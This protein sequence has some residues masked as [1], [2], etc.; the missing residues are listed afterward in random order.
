MIQM[1]NEFGALLPRPPD[2]NGN[3]NVCFVRLRSRFSVFSAVNHRWNTVFG[4]G[5]DR[6]KLVWLGSLDVDTVAYSFLIFKPMLLSVSTLYPVSAPTASL[7]RADFGH[8]VRFY[9]DDVPFFDE[10]TDF[11][12]S[13]LRSREPVIMVATSDHCKLIRR[14]LT[15]KGCDPERNPFLLF[16]AEDT[17]ERFMVNNQPDASR[18]RDLMFRNLARARGGYSRKEQRVTIF[19]EMVAVLWSQGN[20]GAAMELEELWN[21]LARTE[22]FS[23]ICAYPA[24]LFEGSEHWEAFSSLCRKHA[25][26]LPDEGYAALKSEEERLRAI[27]GLQFKARSLEKEM[28]RHREVESSLQ[29]RIEERAAEVEH[30]RTRLQDLSGKLVLMRDQ[31]SQRIARELHDSTSQL[32]SVLAMY[33]DLLE[34]NKEG[35]GPTAAQLIS[36]SNSLVQQILLEVRALSDGLYPPTLDIVGLG[37]AIEWY[38][39]RFTERTGIPV[40][41]DVPESAERLPQ[42]VELAMFRLTQEYLARILEHA[43]G[44]LVTIG[45]NRSAEGATLLV[46]ARESVS[47]ADVPSPSAELFVS[48]PSEVQERV[49]QLNGR[50]FTASDACSSGVSVFFP[51]PHSRDV[52]AVSR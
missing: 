48:T 11:V 46:T 50:V 29:S 33:V 6:A 20:P 22:R 23:L 21:D 17:M 30:T 28:A 13:V 44:S 40:S 32:L 24:R 37:S 45:L 43:P 39:N 31:E 16:E 36:R 1:T 25:A 19:G 9:S 5:R 26:V 3:I 7:A 51:G 8:A 35:F 15:E 47:H 38:C 27:A 2:L 14:M 49:R 12:C 4:R 52:A 10:I 34:A 18:F 42:A 41:L